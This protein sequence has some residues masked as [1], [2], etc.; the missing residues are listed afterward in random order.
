MATPEI[1][2]FFATLRSGDPRTVEELLRQFDPYLRRVIRLRLLGGRLSHAV[3]TTDVLSL[4]KDFLAQ[5]DKDTPLPGAPGGL[6]AY[7]AA[8]VRNKI[9]GKLRKERRHAG[10]LPEDWDRDSPDPSPAQ[11]VER[12]DLCQVVRARL[13]AEHRL[14]FDLKSQGLTWRQVAEQVGGQP[15]ARRQAL[16]R[17][18]ADILSDLED[19]EPSDAR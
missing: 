14:L 7:L 19:K 11:Q 13:S 8:A 3:D 16:R 17:A 6:S 9:R 10:S 2:D 18:I 4:L 12:R 15:D 1:P 5:R